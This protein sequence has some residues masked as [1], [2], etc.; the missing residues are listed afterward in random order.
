MTSHIVVF[1]VRGIS[2][3]YLKKLQIKFAYK[4]YLGNPWGRRFVLFISYFIMNY[5]IELLNIAS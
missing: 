5:F 1:V 3:I 4:I 2:H